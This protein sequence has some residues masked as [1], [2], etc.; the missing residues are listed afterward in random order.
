MVTAIKR[1][2]NFIIGITSMDEFVDMTEKDK[3]LLENLAFW[4]VKGVKN[5][6]VFGN[7]IDFSI[8]LLRHN[9]Y[10][11]KGV[12]DANSIMKNV[13]PK[14]KEILDAY[15]FILE[16]KRWNNQ[17]LI[18]KDDRLFQ[19]CYDFTVTEIDNFA[20]LWYTDYVYGGLEESRDLPM[21][22]SLLFA[23]RNVEKMR[24]IQ[25]FPLMTFNSKTKKK[26][27]YNS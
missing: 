16:G 18:L 10:I 1:D 15:G 5:C 21:E 22:E 17:I 14:M 24:G 11:F 13:L 25:L 27:I 3:A 7:S 6:Y 9:D 12:T 20:S 2:N 26:K 19:V 4:K 8:E 23:I